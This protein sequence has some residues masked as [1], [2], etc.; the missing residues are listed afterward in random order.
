MIMTWTVMYVFEQRLM[1]QC[2]DKI[3]CCMH[4]ICYRT[5]FARMEARIFIIVDTATWKVNRDTGKCRIKLQEDNRSCH[6]HI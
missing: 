3:P 5:Y 2:N 6:A 4:A 1:M